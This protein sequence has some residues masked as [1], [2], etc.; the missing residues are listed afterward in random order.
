M[1]SILAEFYLGNIDPN[2][3]Y[4]KPGSELDRTMK[5]VSDH[6]ERLSALL[7]GA[8]KAMF[9]AFV[10]AQL[11]PQ[12]LIEIDKFSCGFRLGALFMQEVFTGQE[13]SLCGGD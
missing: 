4:I 3:Y 10:S 11:E 9:L 7:H 1:K 2:T 8:E 6:E 12:G 5:A 13:A